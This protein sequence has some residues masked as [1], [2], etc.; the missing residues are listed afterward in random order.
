MRTPDPLIRQRVQSAL[1][2]SA[3]G[4]LATLV[5]GPVFA[6][7]VAAVAILVWSEWLDM[8]MPDAD[9]RA[10]LAGGAAFLLVAAMALWLPPS[11]MVPM[12]LVVFVGVAAWMV[13]LGLTAF[14]LTGLAYCFATIV[15]LVDLRGALGLHAG[16]AAIVMLF[17]IVW[18]TDIGAYFTGRR[19]GGIRLAPTI[20]PGKTLSG[21]LGGILAAIV[22]GLVV[23][24]LLGVPLSIAE[25]VWLSILLSAAAQAGDLFESFMKR[26]AGVKNS[27]EI[28]PGHGGVMDRVDGLVFAAVL[29][30]LTGA[31]AAAPPLAVGL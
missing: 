22:A 30:W 21:A 6:A 1:V 27:S 3:I 2:M 10:L 14:A 9:D 12:V 8:T 24:L 31:L 29:L 28:I 5:G 13:T 7:F 20:S 17:A 15:A 4:L 18:S 16:F 19:F 11:V 26:R 23:R 25:T